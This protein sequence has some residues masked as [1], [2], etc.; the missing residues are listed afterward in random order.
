MEENKKILSPRQLAR[1]GFKN[2]LKAQMRQMGMPMP[3]KDPTEEELDGMIKARIEGIKES[4]IEKD[5]NQKVAETYLIRVAANKDLLA[6]VE[7]AK[8]ETEWHKKATQ[9][10]INELQ[11][12]IDE[13]KL[14]FEKEKKARDRIQEDIGKMEELL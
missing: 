14:S 3:A 2:Q 9:A 4:L 7:L 12:I 11:A 5:A 6:H 13:K 10:E 8:A 1:D